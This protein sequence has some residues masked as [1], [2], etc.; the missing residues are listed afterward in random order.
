MSCLWLQFRLGKFV[1]GG[2]ASGARTALRLWPLSD[3]RP[4]AALG[5]APRKEI[6][7]QSITRVW[8]FGFLADFI[9]AALT[10]LLLIVFSLENYIV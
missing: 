7:K 2:R 1:L 5:L 9:G 10:M 4:L 8:L 6:W 3:P